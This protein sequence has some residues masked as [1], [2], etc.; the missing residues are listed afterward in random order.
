M[1]TAPCVE[2]FCCMQELCMTGEHASR[3]ETSS[4]E[5]MEGA[6]VS[7]SYRVYWQAGAGIVSG[8]ALPAIRIPWREGAYVANIVFGGGASSR[9]CSVASPV[10]QPPTMSHADWQA[11][12]ARGTKPCHSVFACVR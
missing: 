10:S 8:S 11:S 7:A 5:D 3:R 1:Q 6:S 9:A 4:T 12:D 2:T